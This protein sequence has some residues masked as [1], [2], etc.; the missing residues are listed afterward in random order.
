MIYLADIITA[1]PMF[2]RAMEPLWLQPGVA[3]HLLVV[4]RLFKSVCVERS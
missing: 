2:L 3:T 1:V 4:V